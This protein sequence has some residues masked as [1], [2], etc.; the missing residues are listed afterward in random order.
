[1]QTFPCPYEDCEVVCKSQHALHLL[2]QRSEHLKMEF[3][4]PVE[5]CSKTSTSKLGIKKHV[6]VV[7]EGACFPRHEEG[8]AK[9]FSSSSSLARHIKNGHGP[10]T[11]PCLHPGCESVFRSEGSLKSHVKKVHGHTPPLIHPCPMANR[12]GC[13]D[14]RY[15]GGCSRIRCL[16]KQIVLTRGLG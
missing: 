14:D 12:E 8:C 13:W 7:H 10:V 6:E 9:I 4:C 15:R 11:I 2:H 3:P 16:W 5:G 1:M